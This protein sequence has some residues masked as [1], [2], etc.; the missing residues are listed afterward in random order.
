MKLSKKQ[1]VY[2]S[3]ASVISVFLGLAVA[4]YISRRNVSKLQ[5]ILDKDRSFWKG[6]KETDPEVSETLL[7]YWK[8]AGKNFFVQ[9]MQSSNFQSSW[10]WSAAYISNVVQR[11][12]NDDPRFRYSAAHNRFVIQAREYKKAN[13]PNAIY[14]AYENGEKEVEPGDIIVR[15]RGGATTL[16]S[17]NTSTPLHTDI[18]YSVD[19]KNGKVILQG[20]NLSNSVVRFAYPYKDKKIQNN[21]VIAH[22][23]LQNK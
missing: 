15:Q 12:T 6:K 5:N 4:V 13:D 8:S 21:N 18:V 17:I 2:I 20:G 16:E 19:K 14:Y 9:N 11:W 22:L 10:P 3:V 23:K 7:D 1:I